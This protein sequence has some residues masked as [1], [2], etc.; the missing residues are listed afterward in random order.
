MNPLSVGDPLRLGPYR[1]LGVVGEGGMGKV[2]AGQDDRSGP[3]GTIAAVK[4]LHPELAGERDFA[5]RFVRE[6]QSAQAVTSPGVARV[7]ATRTEGGRPWI[8][9][10]FLAGPTLDQ[11]VK[12]HGPLEEAALRSLAASIAGTLE[13]VHAAGLIHRD[14]K[15][16]NIVLTSGGPRVIDF[17]IARPEHGLTL[18]TTGQI[19]VTP[20]Y[21]APEQV[22]GRRVAASAD[23]FSLGAV[24]VYAAGGTRAFDGANVAVLQY[25]V[26][27]GEPR[28]EGVPGPLR[29]LIEPCLAKDPEERP[30]PARI[31]TSFAPPRGAGRVWRRGALAADIKARERGVRE[32]SAATSGTSETSVSAGT[33]GTP[34]TPTAAGASGGTADAGGTG[35]RRPVARRQ[36]LIGGMAAGGAAL[37]GVAGG[38]AWWLDSRTAKGDLFDIPP[39]ADTPEAKLLSA[40]DGDHVPGGPPKALWKRD[41]V[42]D[43]DSPP[44]LPVR[45]VV[46]C[47]GAEGGIVALDVVHGER[48][49]AAEG[50]RR[51]SH[52]LS[53][54]DRLIAAVDIKGVV[55]TYVASTG[56][57]KWKVDADADALLAAD[58]EA[59]YLVT[60]AGELRGVGRSDAK[61]RWTADVP[62]AFRGKKLLPPGIA[63][64]GRLVVR[65]GDGD[66][67]AVDTEDGSKAWEVREQFDRAVRPA[68]Q[69]GTV[70]INGKSLTARALSDGSERWTRKEQ[71]PGSHQETWGPPLAL[72]TAVYASHGRT[73]RRMNPSD[74]RKVWDSRA[75]SMVAGPLA[76]QGRT[77][78]SVD[79]KRFSRVSAVETGGGRALWHCPLPETTRR[80]WLTGGGNRVFV[81]NGRALYALPVV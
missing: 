58:G 44:V 16:Q 38:T 65:T 73:P 34:A 33:R 51:A 6:A 2:Y 67:L 20:G 7:L 1:L 8:A 42:L 24:L 57:P 23:V 41:G 62:R 43:P 18:T 17:G 14:L 63:G 13:D 50:P 61:V 74:G 22:M 5:R 77:L 55:H 29:A 27:H 28:L 69:G 47:T 37:A 52:V 59:V 45:D 46:V 36:L 49:W 79:E 76:V 66:V 71:G 81:M 48:R 53:L 30:T 4:V 80:R 68:V 35:T 15:P 25:E 72:P 54:S 56:E 10:E 78:W 39:A 11:A 40:N 19:P 70:Y 64:G 3:G 75:R 12:A 21:G 31:R 32:L 9:T 60:K 26:V